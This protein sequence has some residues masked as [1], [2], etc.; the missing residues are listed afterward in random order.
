MSKHQAYYLVRNGRAEKAFELREQEDPKPQ[1]N[2]VL[3]DVEGFGLNFADVMAR[4]GS[5]PECPPLPTVIGYDVAGHIKELGSEVKDLKVGDRVTALTLFGGYT[6]RVATDQR[7]VAKIP[8]S[9]DLSQATSLTTQY[10]TAWYCAVHHVNLFPGDKVLIHAAAGGVGT[11]LV[12]IAKWKGCEIFGTAGSPEKLEY[13]RKMGVDHPINYRKQDFEA[14]VK[15]IAPGG[16]DV[17]FDPTGGKSV[18]KGFN[19][20][21]AGGRNVLFG[22]ASMSDANVFGKISAGL[23]FGIYHPAEFMMSSRAL[24]GVNMLRIGQQRPEI[25]KRCL[26]GV[27]QAIENGHIEAP[28]G[29]VYPHTDLAKAHEMLEKRKTTGKLAISWKN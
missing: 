19:L 9:M 26:N 24:I 2:E 17:V 12:Q 15:K 1:P 22:A 29:E 7:A 14:E 4:L 6:Q 20:L 18:K 5:Y 10:C 25:L 27:I 28:G 11:A 21:T 16:I 23:G 13:L 3:I 8:E